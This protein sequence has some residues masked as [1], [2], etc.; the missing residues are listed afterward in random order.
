MYEKNSYFLFELMI[1]RQ[2]GDLKKL[3]LICPSLLG[4]KSSPS[5]LLHHASLRNFKPCQMFSSHLFNFYRKILAPNPRIKGVSRRGVGR[6]VR[7]LVVN[8]PGGEGK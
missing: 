1:L 8:L 5:P 6:G 2:N 4:K 3:K 7:N